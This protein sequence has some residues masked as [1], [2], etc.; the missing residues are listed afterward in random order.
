MAR[1]Y[2]GSSNRTGP[3]HISGLSYCICITLAHVQLPKATC[4]AKL[5]IHVGGGY[6]W[7]EYQCLLL[8]NT[9]TD[10]PLCQD[11]GHWHR[12]IPDVAD[13]ARWERPQLSPSPVKLQTPNGW[14]Q[15][16]GLIDNS[17]GPAQCQ[18]CR[19]WPI[20]IHWWTSNITRFQTLLY[21]YSQVVWSPGATLKMNQDCLLSR[22]KKVPRCKRLGQ[23]FPKQS[24]I[25]KPP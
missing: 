21:N 5:R 16:S 10:L 3:Q 17:L 24:M 6:T 12:L 11:Q 19:E 20:K 22:L 18:A 14:G 15:T 8:T 9:V 25:V 1:F 7:H 23:G 2:E 13:L 4:T